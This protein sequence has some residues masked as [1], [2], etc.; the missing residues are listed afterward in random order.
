MKHVKFND[1][2]VMRELERQALKKGTFVPETKD[3]IKTASISKYASTGDILLDLVHLAQ[4]LR[5]KGLVK[6]AKSLEEKMFVY[7]KA[8]SQYQEELDKA[9]P[10]GDVKMVDGGDL[11]DVETLESQHEKM[12]SIVKKDPTGKQAELINNILKAAQDSLGLKK[13]LKKQ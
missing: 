5:E 8:S 4:G 12:L 3:I 11:A 7:K 9:H 10:D 13:R 6:E 1:S 2:I